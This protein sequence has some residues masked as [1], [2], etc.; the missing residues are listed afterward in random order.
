MLYV[1]YAILGVI[2]FATFA[3]CIDKGL[4][5]NTLTA[6]NILFSGLIAFGWYQPVAKMAAGSMGEYTYLLDFMMLWVLYV[7]AFIVLHR[8]LG[9]MLSKTR[10]RF[11]HPIDT[12]GGPASAAIAGW[13]MTGI[14][15]ASLHAAPFDKDAF[16]GVFSDGTRSSTLTNPDLAWLSICQN[17]LSS[18][19]LGSGEK[20]FSLN[21]YINNFNKQR[22]ALQKEEGLRVRR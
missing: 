8:V 4:W 3:M 11:K 10:M 14:V 12:I 16:G 20:D 9:G 21:T 22:E 15:A 19:H 17:M 5:S 13:L 18:D 1:Y 7:I 6:I 2:F